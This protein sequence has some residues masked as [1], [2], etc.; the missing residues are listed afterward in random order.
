MGEMAIFL[1]GM[2]CKLVVWGSVSV[3][4]LGGITGEFWVRTLP[5]KIHLKASERRTNTLANN[6]NKRPVKMHIIYS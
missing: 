3:M 4:V 6:R 5:K 1:P 2:L